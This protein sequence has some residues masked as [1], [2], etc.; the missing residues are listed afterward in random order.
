MTTYDNGFG[1]SVPI[2]S[3]HFYEPSHHYHLNINNY[4]NDKDDRNDRLRPKF[5]TRP[6]PN[7]YGQAPVIY[8]QP[9]AQ[10]HRKNNDDSSES[11]VTPSAMIVGL[12]NL[13]IF[14]HFEENDEDVFVYVNHDD[15]EGEDTKKEATR[16]FGNWLDF[17]N[18]DNRSGRTDAVMQG[19]YSPR[20]NNQF[21]ASLDGQQ[22]VANRNQPNIN[23]H[24]DHTQQAASGTFSPNLRPLQTPFNQD[25]GDLN[26][27]HSLSTRLEH[28]S[29]VNPMQSRPDLRQSIA[30]WDDLKPT[31]AVETTTDEIPVQWTI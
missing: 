15:V 1:H 18:A 21:F 22:V 8:N 27:S 24:F 23:S 26:L 9:R 2:N 19:N 31:I 28:Q 20:D 17:V 13:I 12:E 10:S 11:T 3:G 5:R 30:E 16:K 25:A 7:P 14:C 4:E 29:V 6:T